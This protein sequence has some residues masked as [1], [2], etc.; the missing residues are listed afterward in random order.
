MP[1]ELEAGPQDHLPIQVEPEPVL[2]VAGANPFHGP[3]R[4]GQ[5]NPVEHPGQRKEVVGR[6]M[7]DPA[8]RAGGG[9]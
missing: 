9:E 3:S 5:I 6:G 4:L 8:Y 7:N 1:G 2:F